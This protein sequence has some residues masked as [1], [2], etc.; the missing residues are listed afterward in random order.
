MDNPP[1]TMQFVIELVMRLRKTHACAK[2]HYHW[3]PSPRVRPPQHKSKNLALKETALRSKQRSVDT[4]LE[5]YMSVFAFLNRAGKGV[6]CFTIFLL[7]ALPPNVRL[8]S[9]VHEIR[10]SLH[11]AQQ[12]V[13]GAFG[14]VEK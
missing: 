5:L 1:A 14:K 8:A 12:S 6:K 10:N 2:P 13:T 11:V 9:E 7:G 3:D 4:R